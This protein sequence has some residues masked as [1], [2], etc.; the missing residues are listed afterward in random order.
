MQ[1]RRRAVQAGHDLRRAGGD[2]QKRLGDA[3]KIGR[4]CAHAHH[5]ATGTDGS[6]AAVMMWRGRVLR[7]D[8]L[9]GVGM[10]VRRA[11]MHMS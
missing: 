7:G 4:Q 8:L 1:G 10:V 5:R 9:M 2:G 6:L 11:V 3:G